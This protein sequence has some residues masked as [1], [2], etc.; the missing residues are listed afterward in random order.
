MKLKSTKHFFLTQVPENNS[1]V[2]AKCY[3]FKI[4]AKLPQPSSISNSE[5]YNIIQKKQGD[6]KISASEI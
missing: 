5:A 6:T 1:K 2:E 3:D 4:S